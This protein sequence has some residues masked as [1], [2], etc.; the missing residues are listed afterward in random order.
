MADTMGLRPI[1][2]QPREGSSPSIPT[3]KNVKFVKQ[4]VLVKKNVIADAME[5]LAKAIKEDPS[6]KRAWKANISCKIYD[7]K[8]NR[9]SMKKTDEIAE[10][11]IKMLFDRK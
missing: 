3:M 9:V 8:Y 10:D 11:I 6:Y 1:G 7:S 2:A 4:A 5:T